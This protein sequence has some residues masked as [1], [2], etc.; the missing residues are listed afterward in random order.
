MLVGKTDLLP[1]LLKRTAVK[2]E[3]DELSAQNRQY[4]GELIAILLQ[5]QEAQAIRVK[6]GELGGVDTCL[7]I[8]SVRCP[9]W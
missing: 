8:L 2:P 6:F 5:S 4:A 3:T 9:S 7:T 1:W